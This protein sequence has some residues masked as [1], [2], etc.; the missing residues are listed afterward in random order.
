[1]LLYGGAEETMIG[2][3]TYAAG[4]RR[5]LVLGSLLMLL[6]LSSLACS[7]DES[8]TSD[9]SD[10]SVQDGLVRLELVDGAGKT[11]RLKVEIADTVEKRTVGLS[12]RDSLPADQGMLFVF[13]PNPIG[14][15]MKNTRIPLAAAFI[16]SCGEIIH[17]AEMQPFSETIHSPGRDFKFGLE[18]NSGWFTEH[19]I[20]VG[21]TVR[22]PA[23]YQQPGC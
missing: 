10:S 11:T 15:W 8:T 16:T 9:E 22:I 19:D 17:I 6:T 18:A 20:A 23:E 14:F 1:M 2:Q 4:V 13:D 7:S 21:D 5:A 3:K 12:G